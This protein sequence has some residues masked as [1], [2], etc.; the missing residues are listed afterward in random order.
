MLTF[1]R[2][3]KEWIVW[4][5]VVFFVG[6]MFSGLSFFDRYFN[7]NQ[8]GA[9]GATFAYMGDLPVDYKKFSTLLNQTLG[10]F[11][12]E[13]IQKMDPIVL[14]LLQ[15]AAFNQAVEYS[16]LYQG[17]SKKDVSPTRQ[18][19]NQSVEQLVIQYNLKNKRQLKDMLK[20][21]GYNWS[22]FKKDIKRDLSVQ[23]FANDLANQVPQV[24]Q[25]DIQD[26]YTKVHAQH[27]LIKG[28]SS[29]S[30]SAI[31]SIQKQVAQGLSF[32]DAA[33]RY[34]QDLGSRS[35]KG[36]LGWV[37][38]GQTVPAFEKVVFSLDIDRLS[39]PVK[40]PYGYHLI[41]VLDRLTQV[42]ATLNMSQAAKQLYK[43][44]QS[45]A[46]QS[47]IQ[48][49]LT[50]HPLVIQENLLKAYHAK[51]AGD[52]MGALGAYQGLS[53]QS[54]ESPI[55][56]YLIANVYV[57][58]NDWQAASAELDKAF[59]KIELKPDAAFPS[60][61]V[62]KGR[63]D[64]HLGKGASDAYSKAISLCGNSPVLLRQLKQ[65]FESIKESS[66]A[67]K[68]AVNEPKAT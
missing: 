29:S 59:V 2:E 57:M 15:Y 54:P 58:L 19:F 25:K 50:Q 62:L 24:T 13:D 40:S 28:T 42:P 3:K 20:K 11:K 46:V 38:M 7:R 4:G 6:T 16:I 9:T 39:A 44:R 67:K 66:W 65:N 68:I 45:K 10:R 12:Q 33:S 52:M 35:K 41:R 36:D 49:Y 27:I 34:S 61:Y 55:P 22:D 5:L 1:F 31:V 63:I 8:E 47:Y 56:H 26:A 64:Q 51:L 43:E 14:E 30:L 53:S 18:E 32:E 60:L 48:T 23:K 17:A 21:N 37:K